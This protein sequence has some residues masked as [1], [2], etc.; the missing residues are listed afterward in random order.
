MLLWGVFYP[1]K[2]AYFSVGLLL[3]LSVATVGGYFLGEQFFTMI[4]NESS[5]RHAFQALVAGS[6]LHLAIDNHDHQR[7]GCASHYH[8]HH[9]EHPAHNHGPE[10]SQTN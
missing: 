2:G 10:S 9:D 4:G 1:K 8:E 5:V 3:M 7:A 6:L